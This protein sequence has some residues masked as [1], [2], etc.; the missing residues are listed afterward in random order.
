MNDNYDDKFILDD[1]VEYEYSQQNLN[2]QRI[3][4]NYS[5]QN[6]NTYNFFERAFSKKF[7]ALT[8]ATIS[9]ILSIFTKFL[10][11]C[12]VTST[13]LFGIIFFFNATICIIS[14][15][16]NILNFAKIKKIELNVS[17][18]ITFVALLILVIL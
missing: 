15:V 4:N 9:I 16:S 7:L 13:V 10:A 6:V 5:N 18:V 2:E 8:L 3:S 17:S 11:I 12:G 1:N 14:L